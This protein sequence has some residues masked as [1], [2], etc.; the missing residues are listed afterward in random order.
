MILIAVL[1]CLSIQRI[2]NLAGS[3]PKAWTLN[4]L[5]IFHGVASKI[6]AILAVCL[7]VIPIVLL[8]GMINFITAKFLYGFFGLLL[9]TAILFFC[10][11]VRDLAYAK[12]DVALSN[13]GILSQAFITIF[14]GLFW[15]MLFGSFGVIIYTSIKLINKNILHI[16]PRFTN[17]SKLA[18]NIQATMDWAPSRILAIS[19]ALV[20]NFNKGFSYFKKHAWFDFYD[21]QNFA[22]ASG[23]AALDLESGA[24]SGKQEQYH[25][26]L[27][28]VN[29]V[30]IIWLVAL[31]F[32]TL[33]FII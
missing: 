13:K 16:D 23:L 27:D 21:A 3:I 20:G 1:L 9:A 26:A 8:L 33:G 32:V 12:K 11:D 10:I 28:L 7:F 24:D 31:F 18:I 30:L 19:Y 17:I 14:P 6:N 25:V 4:Y 15:F 29:R 2:F 5:R 22:T